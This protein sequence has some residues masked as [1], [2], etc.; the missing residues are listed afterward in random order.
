MQ[1]RL[2]PNHEDVSPLHAKEGEDLPDSSYEAKMTY[3]Q[4]PRKFE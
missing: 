1:G 4:N 2:L 3:Q